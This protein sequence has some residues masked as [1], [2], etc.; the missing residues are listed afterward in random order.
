VVGLLKISA[1]R[2]KSDGSCVRSVSREMCVG[3]RVIG[4]GSVKDGLSGPGSVWGGSS[5]SG[6]GIFEVRCESFNRP[7]ASGFVCGWFNS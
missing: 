2:S 5:A 7:V 1:M 4:G 3:G 6:E